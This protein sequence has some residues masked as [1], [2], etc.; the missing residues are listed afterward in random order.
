MLKIA[1]LI[2]IMLGTVFAGIA[3][4]VLL[5]VPQFG[6]DPMKWIPIVCIAA[7]VAAVPFSAIIAKRIQAMTAGR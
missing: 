4:T 3:I 1:A 5:T 7:A 6:N 2:W